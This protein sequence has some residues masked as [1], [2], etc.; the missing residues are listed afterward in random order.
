MTR[1]QKTLRL[2][3]VTL[4]TF[5]TLDAGFAVQPVLAAGHHKNPGYRLLA[6]TNGLAKLARN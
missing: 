2:T 4:T 6:R 1:I 5:A 3:A